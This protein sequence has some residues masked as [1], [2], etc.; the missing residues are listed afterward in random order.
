[1][2][3]QTWPETA[4]HTI[5]GDFYNKLLELDTYDLNH[6]S[7][8]TYPKWA[9]RVIDAE[10]QRRAR[11]GPILTFNSTGQREKAVVRAPTSKEVDRSAPPKDTTDEPKLPETANRST[12]GT[13]YSNLLNLDLDALNRL[14]VTKYPTWARRTVDAERQRRKQ[15]GSTPPTKAQRAAILTIGET[16]TQKDDTM[17][18]P[19]PKEVDRSA[20]P[21]DVTDEPRL[22]ETAN[23]STIGTFYSNLL[24]LDLDALNRLSVAKYPAWARRTVDAER[25]RRKQDGSTPP[26]KAQRAAIL[27]IG[28][29]GTQ[30]DD[31]METLTPKV[32]ASAPPKDVADEPKWPESVDRGVISAFYSKLLTLEQDDLNLISKMESPKWARRVIKAELRRRKKSGSSPPTKAQRAAILTVGETD[33]QKRAIPTA[34]A[35]GPKKKAASLKVIDGGFLHQH[36]ADIASYHL[37]YDSQLTLE[38][39]SHER[40]IATRGSFRCKTERCKSREWK[41]GIVATE[42]YFSKH[43]YSYRTTLY[44][45]ACQNCDEYA[46]PIVDVKRYAEKIVWV[47]DLWTGRRESEEKTS[48]DGPKGPHD[49][50]RCYGC[51]SGVCLWKQRA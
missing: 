26:T 13:F 1:M 17:E 27:T 25:Q 31:T 47:T 5:V 12:I 29:T 33:E 38:N 8:E 18:A 43:S 34:K 16:G 32:D 24:N 20:S 44:S 22:P 39:R 48:Y 3:Q 50:D 42:L 36:V 15:D 7:I 46:E 40:S 2:G 11:N 10:R 51:Y 9:R 49:E 23:R 35:A 45:Q 19:T 14:S 37:T 30:K 28:E 6:L 41:S 4:S 21:K